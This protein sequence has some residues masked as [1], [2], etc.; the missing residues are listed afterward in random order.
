MK[1]VLLKHHM[2]SFGNFIKLPSSF[3]FLKLELIELGLFGWK[4]LE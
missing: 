1:T 2:R 4:K 3:S